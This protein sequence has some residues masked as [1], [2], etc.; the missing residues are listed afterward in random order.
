MVDS[1]AARYQSLLLHQEA[2]M[3]ES[4]IFVFD[5]SKEINIVAFGPYC[6][7]SYVIG[8]LP[9]FPCILQVSGD[10]KIAFRPAK[11]ERD[12]HLVVAKLK[13]EHQPHDL[14]IIIEILMHD[15]T[16]E[17]FIKIGYTM[18]KFISTI[19]KDKKKKNLKK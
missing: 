3:K 2:K 16:E 14:N 1:D 17:N 9:A 11:L 13:H 4:S 10:I 18:K 19:P 6:V 5:L 15:L 8:E 12:D 7:L